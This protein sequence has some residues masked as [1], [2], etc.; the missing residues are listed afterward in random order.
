MK[1]R[2]DFV[3]NSS[4]SSFMVVGCAFE[5]DELVKIVEKHCPDYNEDDWD[6]WAIMEALEEK[7]PDLDFHNGLDNYYDEVCIGL[8]YDKMKD[9]ETRKEFEKRIADR[10]KELTGKDNCKVE[11]L[12]DGGRDDS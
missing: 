2:T 3:S 11:C 12:V 5:L 10:L 8:D 9:D 4:S 6:T 7:F 1:I